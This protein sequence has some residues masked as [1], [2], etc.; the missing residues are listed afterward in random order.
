MP[1]Q[2]V[3]SR[4]ACQMTTGELESPRPKRRPRLV[5]LGYELSA[6]RAVV[7]AAALLIAMLLASLPAPGGIPQQ[8]MVALGLIAMTVLLWAT[9]AI[10]QP[11]AAALFIFLVLVT[12]AAPPQAAAS[13]FLSSS[14]W[15]VFGGLLIGTAAE[16][17]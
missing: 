4:G 3:E 16:R 15:L 5:L 1:H 10:P 8:A 17:T 13:G 2:G 7:L 6:W 12:G 9:M 14:L 11:A